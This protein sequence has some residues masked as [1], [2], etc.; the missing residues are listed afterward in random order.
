MSQKDPVPSVDTETDELLE[1]ILNP[2][3][4]EEDTS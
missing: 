4:E 2:D 3:K 1:E